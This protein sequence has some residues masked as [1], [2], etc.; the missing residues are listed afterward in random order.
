MPHFQICEFVFTAE[1]RF[2]STPTSSSSR[3]LAGCWCIDCVARQF[4][5]YLLRSG[6]VRKI[7]CPTYMVFLSWTSRLSK[8]E[9]Q[10]CSEA[11]P[12]LFADGIRGKLVFADKYEV[13][14]KS[15]GF[16][17]LLLVKN[18]GS[19][20]GFPAISKPFPTAMT[21]LSPT[22]TNY[23]RNGVPVS[24]MVEH[25]MPLRGHKATIWY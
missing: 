22:C 25:L 1:V 17:S 9:W 24:L 11:T 20:P 14:G 19:W 21:R 4:T 12:P 16:S 7:V 15:T 13:G 3:L 23:Y 10:C 18:T 5:C 2:A 8:A 6:G